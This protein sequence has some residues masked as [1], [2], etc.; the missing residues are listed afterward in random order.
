MQSP[1][2]A[3]AHRRDALLR[4]HSRK[5]AP[6]AWRTHAGTARLPEG[7]RRCRHA[8]FPLLPR[9]LADQLRQPEHRRGDGGCCST[10]EIVGPCCCT[11]QRSEAPSQH[12]SARPRSRRGR[13][14]ASEARL[15][16]QLCEDAA[17]IR[18]GYMV[19]RAVTIP[20]LSCCCT[21]VLSPPATAKA[22]LCRH[23]T[24]CAADEWLCAG[25][26]HH[27]APACAA[28]ARRMAMLGRQR[29]ATGV[30]RGPFVPRE[31]H[32]LFRG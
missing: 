26:G 19:R 22:V 3:G 4:Q 16:W 8:P 32:H 23:A 28:A 15:W 9:A 17:G 7:R 27:G 12:L 14:C 30:H 29:A 20:T 24:S 10:N 25:R 2:P 18:A 1:R 6:K 11:A 5:R 21:R 13:S 31:G